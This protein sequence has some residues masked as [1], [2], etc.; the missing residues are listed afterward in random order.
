MDICSIL[1]TVALVMGIVY[2]ILQVL[3][4]KWM[5]YFNLVTSLASLVVALMS[6]L[7]ATASLDA[8]FMV[9]SVIGIFSY[10]KLAEKNGGQ[11]RIHLVKPTAKMLI[12]SAIAAI[13]IFVIVWRV[14]LVTEDASPLL[15]A[16]TL[17]LSALAT[18]WL[19]LSY[20]EQWY[21]WIVADTIAL[22]MFVSQGLWGMAALFF[23][24]IIS[25]V[26]GLIHWHKRGIYV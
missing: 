6:N 20:K 1:Q 4:H 8:Y 16:L 14:L 5:W 22:A 19:T 3:Q 12:I 24:Y 15:D 17:V 10:K 25:S 23:F 13:M 26:I 21:V 11:E 9:M 2:M 7:W 18:W